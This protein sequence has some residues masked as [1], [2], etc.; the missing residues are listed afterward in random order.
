MT[1]LNYK[2]ETVNP[3]RSDDYFNYYNLYDYKTDTMME[4][5]D[6]TPELPIYFVEHPTTYKPLY[7]KLIPGFD[8]YGITKD[9][10]VLS[11]KTRHIN[12]AT[13]PKFDLQ[14]KILKPLYIG[15]KILYQAVNLRANGDFHMTYIHHIVLECWVGLPGNM[16]PDGTDMQTP[17][18][19]NHK[20]NNPHNNDYT[21]LEWCDRF[22]NNS[23]RCP[24][25]EWEF[26]HTKEF[27][28]K[29]LHKLMTRVNDLQLENEMLSQENTPKAERKFNTNQ[30]TID[31]LEAK[32][33]ELELHIWCQTESEKVQGA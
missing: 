20:D 19:C 22:Y 21:N 26:Y 18:E 13:N 10:K 33:E 32:I 2:F 8:G 14:V 6:L 24:S 4:Y 28:E 15:N 11:F 17:P 30:K 16:N 1:E 23:H 31:V 7:F 27:N 12:T 25:N 5:R 3:C 29:Q 9:G